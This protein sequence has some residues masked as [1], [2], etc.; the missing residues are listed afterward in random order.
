MADATIRRTMALRSGD[1]FSARAIIDAQRNLYQTDAFQ[2]VDL[3]PDSLQPPGDSLV[4]LTVRVV[5]GDRYAARGGIGWA[6][7]DCFRMQGGLIDR[8]FLPFAQRLDING[9]VSKIGI[10]APLDGAQGLCQRQARSDPYSATL[11]YYVSATALQPVRARQSR[12]PSLTIFSSTLSEYRAFLRR[13]PIGGALSVTNPLQARYPST[14]A[15]QV[16]LGRTEAEP[17]FFCAVFNACDT[18]LRNFLQRNNRL[19]ALDYSI[20]RERLNAPLRPTGGTTLRF[21]ARHASTLIGSDKTQQF[22]RGIGDASWY[23]N[24]GRGTTLLAHVR[25][26]VVYGGGVTRGLEGF[27]PPQER[28]YAGGPTTVRGFRQNELGPAVYI[29]NGYR[30][31]PEG[32]NLVFR[33]DSGVV[34]ERVVPTGGNTLAV[35][36]VEVQLPSPVIPQLLGLAVFADAGR[37]WNRGRSSSAQ[38]LSDNG[39]VVKITPGVGVRVTSP[40]GIIRVDL[41]YNPYALPAGAAYFNAPLQGVVAP[42]Y[43]VS[44]G[45]RLTVV[46]GSGDTPASQQ[47]GPC[48]QTFRPT[49]STRFLSRLNPSIWI[50][51][52][53]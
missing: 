1:W 3:F 44:P 4:N 31:V 16:E 38:S 28:L 43:C 53:F 5:E 32:G 39:S 27:I 45:N 11:N 14:L 46:S 42:L 51:Q 26:G 17:A 10:G 18:E 21:S 2:R 30:E 13:T 25:G 22:N 50:G 40:F 6:T 29:V 7:L 8:D 15:Y 9:R 37:L 41:G 49:R 52:A 19:A 48:P 47:S 33:A 23:R 34:A 24:I 36:N 20:S 12:I 35:A